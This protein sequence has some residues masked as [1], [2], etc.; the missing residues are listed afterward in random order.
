MALMQF[1]PNCWAVNPMEAAVCEQCGTPLAPGEP[2]LY[3][4][5]LMRA[6][7][8]PVPDTREMAAR[9]LGQRRDQAALPI[10][11]ARLF[12]ET[13]IGVLCASSLALGRLGDCRAVAV[14]AK[15]LAQPNAL[16]VA[17]AIVDALV[18]LAGIGCWEAQDVLKAPPAV[19]ERVAQEIAARLKTLNLLY[20]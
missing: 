12:E 15:R 3:D 13:D 18:T 19:S 6:L 4:Q 5:K 9:L 11:Q 8:H 14:L 10:L 7:S 17:L 16:V 1:C 20:Y 2:V